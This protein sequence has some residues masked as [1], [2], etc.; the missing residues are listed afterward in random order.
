MSLGVRAAQQPGVGGRHGVRGGRFRVPDDM[1]STRHAPRASRGEDTCLGVAS[2][3]AA[4][5]CGIWR[6][7]PPPSPPRGL[8]SGSALK[9]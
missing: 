2:S 7:E 3:V 9:C 1:G 5:R 6:P 4:G 8:L